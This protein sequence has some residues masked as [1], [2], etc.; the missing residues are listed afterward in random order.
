MK[1][2]RLMQIEQLNWGKQQKIGQEKQSNSKY[3]PTS[4]RKKSIY[5][6]NVNV[7]AN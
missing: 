3:I 5:S 4:E 2:H 6:L 1:D 7:E